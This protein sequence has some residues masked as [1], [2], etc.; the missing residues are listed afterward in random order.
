MGKKQGRETNHFGET[1]LARA[2]RVAMKQLQNPEAAEHQRPTGAKTHLD[3]TTV[4]KRIGAQGQSNSIESAREQSVNLKSEDRNSGP[5]KT[6]ESFFSDTRRVDTTGEQTEP[7]NEPG[8]FRVLKFV[9]RGK[10]E[11][12]VL[13]G[14]KKLKGRKHRNKA[15]KQGQKKEKGNRT[16]NLKSNLSSSKKKKTQKEAKRKQPEKVTVTSSSPPLAS[17]AKK[18]KN[19]IKQENR[20]ATQRIKMPV[21]PRPKPKI[22]LGRPVPAPL[23]WDARTMLGQVFSGEVED[24]SFIGAKPGW[25]SY[26]DD[27]DGAID[28]V[29]G[30]DFGTTFTKVVISE[31]GSGRSWAVPLSTN[32]K[33]P[34]L[35]NSDVFLQDGV[36]QLDSDGE[37]IARLK[38]P[39]LSTYPD[40]NCCHHAV[41]FLALIVRFAKQWFLNEKKG[42]LRGQEPFW[43]VNVGLP[44]KDFERESL[45]DQYLILAWAGLYLSR[46]LGVEL[47]A[48]CVS[49][50]YSLARVAHCKNYKFLGDSD[51]ISVHRDQVH[52]VPEIMAQL[53]GFVRSQ[54]W[55]KKKPEFMLV[56]IGGGTI[57]STVFN[58]VQ[59]KENLELK[60][61]IFSAR[62]E[63]LG[64]INLH[65]QRANWILKQVQCAEQ[66]PRFID[67]LKNMT[68]S[69]SKFWMVPDRIED[70]LAGAQFGKYT[71]D[72]EFLAKL[73][74][75][76]LT[77]QLRYVLTEINPGF[78]NSGRNYPVILA[79]GGSTN[80]LYKEL[81]ASGIVY[82]QIGIETLQLPK[83]ESLDVPGLVQQEYHRISV[84]YGLSFENLG[85][86]VTPNQIKELH[87]KTDNNRK[88]AAATFVSKEMT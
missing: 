9:S 63:P 10:E 24:Y 21:R 51:G 62:V 56:D 67:A 33:N 61:A 83:P 16:E 85:D 71:F 4:G 60:F 45:V 70:Y 40:I 79:G 30:L 58:V 41:A 78:K 18:K 37:R 36:Y 84:A 1:A 54:H 82:Q 23:K 32:S 26:R 31:S 43:F 74:K 35:I 42:F 68:A 50:A 44:A 14:Y 3:S 66:P 7:T 49:S 27:P 77:E 11:R 38:I 53:Y 86:V 52:V 12:T 17:G 57:D 46:A 59:E 81:L 76:C 73:K 15:K 13:V 75:V 47:N 22:M 8:N 80:A 48:E 64:T 72:H 19:N 25:S 20:Q 55:D 28:L 69:N 65:R 87:I 2:F 88:R 29:I 6:S 34:Y 5:E 39:F